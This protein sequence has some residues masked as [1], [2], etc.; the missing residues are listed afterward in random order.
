[1]FGVSFGYCDA[2]SWGTWVVVGNE[3]AAREAEA[4]VGNVDIFDVAKS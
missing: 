3:G 1:V 2:D 4:L